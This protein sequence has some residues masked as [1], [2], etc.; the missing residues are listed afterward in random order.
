MNIAGLNKRISILSLSQTDMIFMWEKNTDIWANVEQLSGSNL[1][2]RVGIGAKS[3]K[4]TIRKRNGL[5][6]NNAF[7]WQGKHCFLTDIKAIDRAYYEVSAALIEPRICKIERTQ[8]PKRNELNRPIYGGP[9]TIS[10]PGCLT[11]KYMGHTQNEPMATKEMRYVLVTPKI[12]EL[13]CG[14]LVTIGDIAYN[15]LISHALDE[16]KNEYEIT[17]KEDI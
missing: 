12:I 5:T 10:F 8:K 13:E 3:I 1:F 14:E 4:F 7:S 6:L 16:Y 11:E 15:V 9:T 2:S 17:V